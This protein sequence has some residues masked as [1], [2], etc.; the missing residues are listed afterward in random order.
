MFTAK[1]VLKKLKEEKIH[2]DA[3][4][5]AAAVIIQVA[6]FSLFILFSELPF[7]YENNLN[8]GSLA[9]IYCKAKIPR[10]PGK[11]T[12]WEWAQRKRPSCLHNPGLQL[13]A[14]FSSS[15]LYLWY[16]LI[17]R[18]F[19]C[20]ELTYVYPF[21]KLFEPI[22]WGR[23]CEPYAERSGCRLKRLW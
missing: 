7:F 20:I 10:D 15:C 17:A 23:K 22:V 13:A 8:S 12:T 14:L 19:E 3:V 1:K 2:D 11:A 18:K 9:W 6:H 21:R 5:E 16:K 4:R